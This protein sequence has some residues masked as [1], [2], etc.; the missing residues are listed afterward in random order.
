L[1]RTSAI[2][3]HNEDSP[4]EQHVFSNCSH[5]SLEE[6]RSQP[7]LRFSSSSF[8]RRSLKYLIATVLAGLIS[9]GVKRQS[10]QHPEHCNQHQELAHAK[11]A[12]PLGYCRIEHHS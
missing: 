4:S 7:F 8:L 2:N 11:T 10:Q 9:A 3:S 6:D 5:V 12:I 1:R